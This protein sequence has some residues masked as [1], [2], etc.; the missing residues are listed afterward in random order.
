VDLPHLRPGQEFTF[1]S[2]AFPSQT[3]TGRVDIVSEFIDANT[4]SIKVRGKMDNARRLLKA[5]MFVSVNLPSEK[6]AGASV[7]SKAVFLQGEQHFVFLETQDGQF[8]RREVQIGPE[9]DG[10]VAVLAGLQAGQRVVTEGCL[11]LQQLLK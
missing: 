6:T 7:P 8:A 10:H 11:L 1:T 9:Q 3:F 4:R 5:E 2:H